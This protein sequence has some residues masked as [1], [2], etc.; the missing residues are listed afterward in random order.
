MM[1]LAEQENWPPHRWVYDGQKILYMAGETGATAFIPQH[2]TVH[3]VR[4]ATS[5]LQPDPVTLCIMHQT[6]RGKPSNPL[7]ICL[8]LTG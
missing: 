6:S 3:E 7:P 4:T 1:A 5:S 8:Q 2:E